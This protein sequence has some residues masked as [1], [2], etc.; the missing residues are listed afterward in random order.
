MRRRVWSFRPII[1]SNHSDPG[2]GQWLFE[3]LNAGSGGFEVRRLHVVARGT[4]ARCTGQEKGEAE[5]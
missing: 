4:Y 5:S 1:G 3:A 2:I